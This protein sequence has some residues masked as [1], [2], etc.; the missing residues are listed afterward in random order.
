[1]SLS[2]DPGALRLILALLVVA[3]HLSDLEV[4]RPAVFVFFLLSGY[5]VARMY[6]Q[7]YRPGGGVGVFWLSRWLRLWLT[8][9]AVALLALAAR[10]LV[11]GARPPAAA[12]LW[13]LGLLGI[14]SHHRDPV[15]T[16]WSLDIELQFYLL[17]PLLLPLLAGART[18]GRRT[19]LAAA[20]LALTA[21]GWVLQQ[22]LGLVTVLAFLPPFLAGMAIWLRQDAGARTP[23]GR[24]A[25][26][27]VAAFLGI[28]LAVVALPELRPLMLRSVPGP[29]HEDL[30]GLG[31]TL[32]LL[33]FL[34][35]NLA[36]PGRGLDRHLGNISFPLYIVH[37]P[38]IALLR[39]W[40]TALPEHPV[41][42]R[43][44]LLAAVALVTLAAY[45]AIDRPAERLRAAVISRLNRPR[46]AA[47]DPAAI[48]FS[49]EPPAGPVRA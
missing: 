12:E 19:A 23:S 45:L 20:A 7:R 18:P 24:A 28:G 16:A 11:P 43:L 31:W 44:A 39:P 4:G 47:E 1:M 22:A 32:A 34:A 27:S 2:F 14:A 33:P 15:G 6:D 48:R 41:A 9:A 37:W 29:I 42:G 10:A 13:S 38:V 21:A 30:F 3:S 26:L 17:L 36:Q 25:A 49:S 35:W 46:P 5:W 8:F 40:L